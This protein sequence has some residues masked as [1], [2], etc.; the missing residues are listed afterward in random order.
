MPSGSALANLVKKNT[1]PS[2]SSAL[3]VP[4]ESPYSAFADSFVLNIE[5]LKPCPQKGSVFPL[6]WT[7]THLRKNDKSHDIVN[8]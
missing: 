7:N 3:A 5:K 4:Q 8:A 1:L 6:H 2:E